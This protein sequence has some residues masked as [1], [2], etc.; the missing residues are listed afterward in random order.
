MAGLVKV[1]V[2]VMC[3]L[4]WEGVGHAGKVTV[5]RRLD[6]HDKRWRW[7]SG[8]KRSCALSRSLRRHV[9]RYEVVIKVVEVTVK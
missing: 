8:S 1:T 2:E 6:G 7:N 5:R 4:S 9:S 3:K